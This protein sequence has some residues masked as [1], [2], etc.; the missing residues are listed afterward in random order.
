MQPSPALLSRRVSKWQA[1]PR[2]RRVRFLARSLATGLAL[3]VEQPMSE[4]ALRDSSRD[5]AGSERWDA[6][7]MLA[8]AP[9]AL[10]TVLRPVA[11]AWV[12]HRFLL[13]AISVVPSEQVWKSPS[14]TACRFRAGDPACSRGTHHPSGLTRQTA[15]RSYIRGSLRNPSSPSGALPSFGALAHF[16]DVFEHPQ[17]A[18]IS[19]CRFIAPEWVAI[20]LAHD[21]ILSLSL[22]PA[23]F[24]SAAC[25]GMVVLSLR[26]IGGSPKMA[27]TSGGD[28]LAHGYGK[29]S[30]GPDLAEQKMN[31]GLAEC[32]QICQHAPDATGI[33]AQ[34]RFEG[35]QLVSSA[36]S[37]SG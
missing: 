14:K 23:A 19:A 31:I 13:R 26:K 8:I 20:G 22:Q 30:A 18:D 3:I 16:H 6:R 4:T 27:Q 12:A 37:G 10:W 7:E 9:L 36:R 21:R 32:R 28:R 24:R 29:R 5:R 34:G 33:L 35:V 11:E 25:N 1:D 2:R 15:T 17:A